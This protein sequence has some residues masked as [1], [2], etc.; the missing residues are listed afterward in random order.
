MFF[1]WSTPTDHP[2]IYWNMMQ[3]Q[4]DLRKV[5]G[6]IYYHKYILNPKHVPISICVY[7]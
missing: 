6:F 4:A 2:I 5:S 1:S 3:N 7:V